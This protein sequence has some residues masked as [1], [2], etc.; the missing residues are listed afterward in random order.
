MC[1]IQFEYHPHHMTAALTPFWGFSVICKVAWKTE[2]LL[3]NEGVNTCG[4]VCVCPSPRTGVCG[5][6]HARVGKDRLASSA[7]WTCIGRVLYAYTTPYHTHRS[8]SE[9]N[10]VAH[11]QAQIRLYPKRQ[12]GA[13]SKSTA[14]ISREGSGSNKSQVIEESRGS[15]VGVFLTISEEPRHVSVFVCTDQYIQRNPDRFLDGT[16]SR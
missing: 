16:Q 1:V 7:R 6:A 3:G 11:S 13:S 9:G 5:R 2:R 8:V 12:N 14:H 10:E 15:A 4:S